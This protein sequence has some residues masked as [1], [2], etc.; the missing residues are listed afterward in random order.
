[1]PDVTKFIWLYL[2]PFH[3]SPMILYRAY[4]GTE[5]LPVDLL[6]LDKVLEMGVPFPLF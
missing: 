6:P 4:K 2:S 3:H 5:D 1:M